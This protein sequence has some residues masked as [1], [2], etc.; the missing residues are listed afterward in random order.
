MQMANKH[1]KRS[2][3]LL[4]IREMQIKTTMG[5][6][7]TSVRITTIKK[8]TN[9]KCWRW[10]G[11]KETLVHCWWECKLMQPLWKTVWKLFKKLK[12]IKNRTLDDHCIYYCGQESLRRNG[13]AIIVNKSPKCST[14]MQSQKWQNDLSSFLRQT[15]QYQS[16]SSLCPDQ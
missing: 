12:I 9:N 14:W 15:I 6:H 5:C 10:C 11:E 13:V 2:L 3:T 7:L 4:I 8:N 16:N 1:I